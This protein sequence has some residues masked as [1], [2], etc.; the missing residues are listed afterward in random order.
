MFVRLEWAEMCGKDILPHDP[1]SIVKDVKGVLVTD[2][3]S[4][5]DIIQKGSHTTSGFGLKEKYS[6]LEV[7]SLFQRLEMCATET[8]WVHSGA[9]LA[10]SLTKPVT[11]GTLVRVLLNG[12]WTLVDDPKFTSE[13]RLRR[14]YRESSSKVLGACESG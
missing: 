13:K 6:V 8:R 7:M 4:L 2:A 10:D 3:K 9:Q 5:F 11:N 12:T 14:T 1:T